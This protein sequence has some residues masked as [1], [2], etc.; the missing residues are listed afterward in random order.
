[1]NFIE[2]AL[3]HVR[4]VPLQ[5]VI[6]WQRLAQLKCKMLTSGVNWCLTTLQRATFASKAKP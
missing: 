1:M 2:T 3:M 6:C 4:I 5:S